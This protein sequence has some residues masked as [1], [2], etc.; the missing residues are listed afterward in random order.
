MFVSFFLTK[1]F[2]L[3]TLTYRGELEEQLPVLL[4]LKC[5]HI[6]IVVVFRFYIATA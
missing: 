3:L 5:Q 2:N 4:A 1:L 6:I